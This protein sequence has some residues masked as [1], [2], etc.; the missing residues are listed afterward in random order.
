MEAF[1]PFGMRADDVYRAVA[2]G[3]G[4]STLRRKGMKVS[5]IWNDRLVSS[6]ICPECGKAAGFSSPSMRVFGCNKAT[7]AALHAG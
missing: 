4:T 5:L 7:V 2:A 3:F 1:F 6:V